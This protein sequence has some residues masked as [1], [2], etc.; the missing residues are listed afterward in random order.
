MFHYFEVNID[1]IKVSSSSENLGSEGFLY[2]WTVTFVSDFEFVPMLI[3]KWNSSS[4]TNGLCYNC[5]EFDAGADVS[6]R[7]DCVEFKGGK[8]E[9]KL[10]CTDL[11]DWKEVQKLQAGDRRQG[12][13]FG[14][15][16]DIDGDQIAVGADYSAA[17]ATSTWDFESGSLTGYF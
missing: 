10:D 12:D 9:F 7:V 4:S 1:E 14:I 15:S 17:V 13:R 16:L 11:A 8:M 3:P 6:I 2:S 5:K